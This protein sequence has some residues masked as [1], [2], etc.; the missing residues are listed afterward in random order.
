MRYKLGKGE[1][2][3][4]PFLSIIY[5]QKQKCCSYADFLRPGHVQVNKMKSCGFD[6]LPPPNEKR[7]QGSIG[8]IYWMVLGKFGFIKS[9]ERSI[10]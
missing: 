3:A 8:L 7:Q 5:V 4:S 1:A 10:I 2:F 6:D 9:Q